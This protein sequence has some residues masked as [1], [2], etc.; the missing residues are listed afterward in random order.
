M[1]LHSLAQKIIPV[2]AAIL[3]LLSHSKNVVKRVQGIGLTSVVA[4]WK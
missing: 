3:L 4:I 2:I 1:K